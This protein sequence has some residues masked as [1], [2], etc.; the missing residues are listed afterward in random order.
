MWLS[1]I[2]PIL[3]V[4]TGKGLH[5]FGVFFAGWSVVFT[6]PVSSS[7]CLGC[8]W[9]MVREKRR[10]EV[11]KERYPLRIKANPM[12]PNSIDHR[13]SLN[14]TRGQ[15]ERTGVLPCPLRRCSSP[16]KKLCT[17]R[18]ANTW[19][20]TGARRSR[21]SKL[22]TRRDVTAAPLLIGFAMANAIHSIFPGTSAGKKAPSSL[23]PSVSPKDSLQWL[24]L[25]TAPNCSPL[26]K[27]KGSSASNNV[28]VFP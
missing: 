3:W 10:T 24:S 17:S 28:V 12:S 14:R 25:S 1:V 13:L 19:N 5:Y 2:Q 16:A 22:S 9:S 20:G 6:L 8:S 26:R 4:K 23:A 11:L 7:W 15:G 18:S 27:E 21:W